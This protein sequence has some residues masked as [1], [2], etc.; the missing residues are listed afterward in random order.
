MRACGCVRVR[1][2]VRV[3]HP[4]VT[5]RDR[6]LPPDDFIEYYVIWYPIPCSVIVDNMQCLYCFYSCI[7]T[8]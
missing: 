3:Q 1:V 2:R 7:I 6:R 8:E 4:A 5:K